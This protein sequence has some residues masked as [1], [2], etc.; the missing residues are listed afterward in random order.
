M[1]SIATL[2]RQQLQR[3]QVGRL[4]WKPVDL[5]GGGCNPKDWLKWETPPEVNRGDALPWYVPPLASS[6]KEQDAF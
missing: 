6:A 3:P 5:T 4:P 1:S 2:N